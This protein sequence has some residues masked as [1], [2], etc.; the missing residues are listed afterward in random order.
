M[1]KL[2]WIPNIAGRTG[3][4]YLAIADVIANDVAS[5]RLPVGARL[6]THRALAGALGVTIATI[7]RAYAEAERRGLIDG[8]AGRG[9]FVRDRR[10]ECSCGPDEAARAGRGF[11]DLSR[12]FPLE[13]PGLGNHIEELLTKIGTARI[14]ELVGPPPPF[15]RPEHREAGARWMSH[16]IGAADPARTA[17][18]GGAQG[19]IM[20]ALTA[21]TLPGDTVLAESLSHPCL[22]PVAQVTGTRIAGV[23]MDGEGMI[24]EALSEACKRHSPKAVFVAPTFQNPTGSLMPFQR[25]EAI[26]AI[27]RQHGVMIVED[28]TNGL[29]DER[30]VPLSALAPERAIFL[31]AC[32]ETLAGSVRIGFIHAPPAVMQRA[33]GITCLVA[34]PTSSLAAE[35][36]MHMIDSG[37]AL[38]A[39]AWK[40]NVAEERRRLALDKFPAGEAVAHPGAPQLWLRLSR[41]WSGDSFAAAARARGI[42][43]AP[44]S[45][46]AID[47]NLPKPDGVR[48]G[49]TVIE[50]DVDVPSALSTLATLLGEDGARSES[51][52][53]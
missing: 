24:P 42:G 10:R 29:L 40:R 53:A 23:E 36:A 1:P 37:G 41:P 28:D 48:I 21:L 35:L 20:F 8:T 11:A 33:A 5:G 14:S 6:P 32:A 49:L 51:L 38:R 52:A 45:A 17:I 18:V 46:F 19:G 3:P 31:T 47:L 43:V 34:S 9:T 16:R 25:R 44:A 13:L 50:K 2:K 26:V 39:A 27:C 4:V 7:T 15:G 12:S 30:S 22:R